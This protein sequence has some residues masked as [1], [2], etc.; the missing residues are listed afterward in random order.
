MTKLLPR[1]AL[2]RLAFL[3]KV[4]RVIVI[5]GPRQSG[6]TTLLSQYQERHGGTIISLDNDELLRWAV[7]DPRTVSETTPKPVI[8]DEVQRAGD[9]LV[10]AIKYLVDR[11]NSK[12][13]FVLAGSTRFLT[14]PT[15]SE[16]LAG[17]AGFVNLWPFSTSER[18]GLLNDDLADILIDSPQDLIN[19]R[20]ST[21]TRADYLD[22]MCTGGYPEVIALETGE[23]R[24]AWFVDYIQTVAQRDVKQFTEIQHG[25]MIPKLLSLVAARTGSTTSHTDLSRSVELSQPTIRNYL[26]YLDT[27]FLMNT[28]GAW[29]ANLSTKAAKTP[30]RYITDSGLAAYLMG[31]TPG[32][33][34]EPTNHMSG[35]LVETFVANELTKIIADN[36][37]GTTL[38]YFRDRDGREIDFI[39]ESMDGRMTAIEV[40]ATTS[41]KDNDF[42]H[43]IWLRDKMGDRFTG[44][45]VFHL[46]PYALSFGDRLLAVPISALWRHERLR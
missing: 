5:N 4:F 20:E 25:E 23:Q 26:S 41:V 13:Q 36:S 3:T 29:S 39:L 10:L 12:G 31:S 15:L 8:I 35:P 40:K 33:L 1:R 38:Q 6:K 34:A 30:R 19:H 37:R 42:R 9:P 45:I 46:G 22:L 32:S 7:N 44:G 11:D 2:D 14:V 18:V 16:S 43:L 28:V 27:V 21:W 24:R 17:R